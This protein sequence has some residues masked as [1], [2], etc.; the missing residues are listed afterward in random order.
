[1][2]KF[3]RDVDVVFNLAALIGIPYS[4]VAP[5]QYIQTNV[6]GTLNILTAVKKS[7]QAALVHTSTSEVYGSAQFVPMTEDHPINPQSPYAASKAGADLLALSYHTSFQ[8]PVTVVR[9]FNTFGPRQ[10]TRAIIPTLL[11]QFCEKTPRIKVGALHPTRDFTFVTDTAAGFIAAASTDRGVGKVVQLGSNFEVSVA[12]IIEMLS[13]ITGRTPTV[14]VE[15]N[16]MRP[17][18]SE[19]QRLYADNSRARE[20]F[21][22]K[23]EFAG[24]EG[25]KRALAITAAWFAEP[26][27]RARYRV[28][29]YTI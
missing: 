29:T 15:H 1:M 22:W 2:E 24:R 5:D 8:L 19:V 13:E 3:V 23:P 17:E 16:R 21:G 26:G 10:S 28:A 18:A 7:G 20:L 14:E 25:F 11:T 9:P 12:E 27:N 4:Y 6:T